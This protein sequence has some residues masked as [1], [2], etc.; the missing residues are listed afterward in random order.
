MTNYTNYDLDECWS[1]RNEWTQR[2][3]EKKKWKL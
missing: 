1:K 3:K 2:E